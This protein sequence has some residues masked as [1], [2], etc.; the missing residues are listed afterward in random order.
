MLFEGKNILVTGATG[1]IGYNLV[2]RLLNEGVSKIYATGRSINKL[3]STFED[4]QRDSLELLEH[5]AAEPLSPVLKDLDYIFHAAG[6]MERD[7]VQN[8]PVDVILP[9]LLGLINCFEFLKE[10]EKQTGRKG[11]IIVFS[12]VTVYNNP[13][14]VD[15]VASED[16]TNYASSLDLSTACYSESKRMCEVIAKSYSKQYG[17][18]AV[19]ARFSTVYGYTK[20]IPNTAFFEFVNKAINGQDI[21]LTGTGLP[22]RDNIYIDDAING[23]LTIA[24]K[25]VK[26]ESYNISSDGEK[27]HFA[28]VDEIAAL[29]AKGICE[30]Y[31]TKAV[32]II[33]PNGYTKRKPG[34]RLSNKKLKSLGWDLC[35][36]HEEGIVETIKKLR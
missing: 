24:I 21:V 10:Q 3:C 30:V 17:I 18:D 11:R 8:R 15:F 14:Q 12:S 6:P 26:G 34:V 35:F 28:A 29:I 25:G 22:R 9:N 19:V 1:L 31:G 33:M 23:L 5:D 36:S 13:T 20:N 32:N 2:C 27:G 7:I 4:Y 16:V